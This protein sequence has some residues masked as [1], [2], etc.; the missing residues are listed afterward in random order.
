MSLRLRS[1]YRT[2]EEIVL[3][4]LPAGTARLVA[5]RA[6]G[7]VVEAE[8]AQAARFRGLGLAPTPCRPSTPGE[9]RRR[10]ANDNRRS[11]R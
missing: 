1:F 5:T 4:T 11:P 3:A 6:T 10:R 7:E 2:G 9:P 8:L